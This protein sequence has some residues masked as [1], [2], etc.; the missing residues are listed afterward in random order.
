MK[1]DKAKSGTDDFKKL[2]TDIAKGSLERCYVF[3]G[4][5]TYLRDYCLHS[6]LKKAVL[7]NGMEDFNLIVIEGKS[8]TIQALS[9]AIESYPVMADKKMI[10]VRDFDIL[11]P[12]A[13]MRDEL[14]D[15]LSDLP[16]YV[17]MVFVY[18]TLDFE[19]DKRLKIYTILTENAAIVH[20][21]PA[22]H[23]ELIPWIK[24]RFA[25]LKKE[26]DASE[27]EYLIFYCGALMSE[28]ALEIEKIAA[29]AKGEKIKK[30][31]IEE[32]AI[33]VLDAAIYNLTD[34]IAA[35]NAQRAMHML[36]ELIQ[37]GTDSTVLL[38]AINRQVLRLYAAK[39]ALMSG[40]REEYIMKMLGM[41][42]R[43]PAEKLISAANKMDIAQLE[44][45]VKLCGEADMEFKRMA[46]DKVRTVQ[47]LL[48]Q[49]LSKKV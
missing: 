17:C 21:A 42:S 46:T 7:N 25:F 19:P 37:M 45:A 10:I 18:D 35:D 33:K 1:K 15:I 34:A 32:V 47:L 4:E 28:L 11:K 5:E 40:K 14:C 3:Y 13:D 30:S 23:E 44:K 29:Y 16:E 22:S 43:Y 36:D 24:K 41:R 31:D 49:I 20:F 8:L 39:A 6:E 27:C 9:D 2:K 38:A 48:V 26:I 12:P